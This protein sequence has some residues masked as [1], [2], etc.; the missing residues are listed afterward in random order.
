[1]PLEPQQTIAETITSDPTS[2]WWRQVLDAQLP[3]TSLLVRFGLFVWVASLPSLVILVNIVT[4][5][6]DEIESHHLLSE[7]VHYYLCSIFWPVR[8]H[9]IS[10]EAV[11]LQIALF[12]WLCRSYLVKTRT[13]PMYFRQ[14]LPTLLVFSTNSLITWM[15]GI[16]HS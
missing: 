13:A 3:T 11:L 2:T 15:A 14:L 12:T 8:P 4:K 1:M 7:A 9:W 6:F 5:Q 16:T 10:W